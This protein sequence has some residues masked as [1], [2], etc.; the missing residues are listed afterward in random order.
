MRL[1]PVIVELEL[2]P[3][4]PQMT[5]GNM[6][7]SP[8]DRQLQPGPKA[9]DAVNVA[10]PDNID[11]A[12]QHLEH[13]CFAFGAASRLTKTLAANI[14][15]IGFNIPV[16]WPFVV[17]VGH[18]LSNL[19]RH[20]PCALVGYAELPLQL[21]GRDAV[22]GRREQEHGVKPLVNRGA[23]ALHRRTDT[24]V[25]VVFAMLAEIRP[26][27]LKAVEFAMLTAT[28]AIN[29]RTAIANIHDMKKA[30]FIVRELLFELVKCGHFKLLGSLSNEV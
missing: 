15:F 7:M 30:S 25:N 11:A 20:A 1:P 3:I 4:P 13:H 23:G 5:T 19:V 26:I 29:L 27:P 17:H 21:F 9:V 18:E 6:N 28:G 12:F 22:T 2:L 14:G 16:K 8:A 24:G 10:A